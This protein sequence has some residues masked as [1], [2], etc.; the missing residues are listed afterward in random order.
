MT[1]AVWV[2]CVAAAAAVYDPSS[3]VVFEEPGEPPVQQEDDSAQKLPDW[4]F[5]DVSGSVEIV[6]SW[7]LSYV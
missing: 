4:A 3:P 2:C 7:F 5:M 6:G 1:E